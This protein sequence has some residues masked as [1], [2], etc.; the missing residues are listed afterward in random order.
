MKPINK[1][2]IINPIKEELTTDSGLLLT[3]S[4]ADGM[5]YEKAE[6]IAP[7]TE[8]NTIKVGDVI[9][10]D[11]RQGYSVLLEKE[12]YTIILERDVVVV[13]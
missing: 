6:V 10:Y 11:K 9:Y 8:V 13:L 12:T 1:Y 4:D 3:G 5:R 2:I 7:G